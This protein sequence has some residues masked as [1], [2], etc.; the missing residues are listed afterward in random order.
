MPGGGEATKELRLNLGCG[1]NVAPGWINIDRSPGLILDRVRP[2]KSLLHRFGAVGDEHM[3]DWPA[4]IKRL[5]VT[6][7]LP[8][9]TGSVDAIY[10]SH[11]LEHLYFNEAQF[12]LRECFRV[13]RDGGILRLA[14]PDAGAFAHHLVH[15]VQKGS[16]SAGLDFNIALRAHPLDRPRMRGRIAARLGANLH[17]WQPTFD[18]VVQLLTRAGFFDPQRKD[19]RVGLLPHLE[20]LEHREGSLFIETTR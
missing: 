13:L 1:T 18:L 17:R 7:G 19:F 5:D 8:F 3:V 20:V 14:L 6:R 10:S 16:T 12:V 9:P 4:G 15:S 11:M 2:L